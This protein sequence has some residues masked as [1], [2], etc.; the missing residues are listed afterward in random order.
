MSFNTRKHAPKPEEDEP[1][2]WN[3]H[4][5]AGKCA[6]TGNSMTHTTRVYLSTVSSR[7]LSVRARTRGRKINELNFI[8]PSS[9]SCRRMAINLDVA[10]SILCERQTCEQ[11][12]LCIHYL[13]NHTFLNVYVSSRRASMGN[14]TIRQLMEGILNATMHVPTRCEIDKGIY[15]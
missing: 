14:K 5:W 1:I 15:K 4:K 6:K 3:R 2:Q 11:T 9:S 7:A 13:P 10:T 12:K 8:I